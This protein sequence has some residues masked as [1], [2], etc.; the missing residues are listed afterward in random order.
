MKFDVNKLKEMNELDFEQVAN[1]PFEVK[2]VVALFVAILVAVGGYYGLISSK[3]PVLDRTQAEEVELK[4]T[5]AAKYRIAVNLKA[6]EEQ[7]ARIEADFS[8]MLK[9]LP[10]SNETPGLIDD[11]T[12]V[13]T[14]AGL[15]FKLI[16]WQQEIPKEFYTEL[17]IQMEVTG[18][19]HEFGQF[20]S[21]IAALP[22]IVTLHN[23]DITQQGSELRL[24]LQAKTYRTAVSEQGQ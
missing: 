14:T 6:Y 23:F 16:N 1:W 4:Q 24:Q 9:S 22:R 21:N 12:F 7:L 2:T 13:G 5:F 20:V 19:Y 17:P 8:S 10:T 3:L 18:N 11:I 15:N